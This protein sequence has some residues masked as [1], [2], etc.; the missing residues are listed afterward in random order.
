M[1]EDEMNRIFI[2]IEIIILLLG[3][4]VAPITLSLNIEGLKHTISDGNTLYV[5]GS[6]HGNYSKIQYAINNASDGDTIF[7][8][9]GIYYEDI[10][11]NKS[12]D[13][14]GE[15]REN[16]I[17]DGCREW[18]VV[19]ILADNVTVKNFYITNSTIYG[20]NSGIKIHGQRENITI[21]NNIIIDNFFGICVGD[22][23]QYER[24]F[25]VNISNNYFVNNT[26][27]LG[28][29]EGQ[30]SI[31]LNNIFVN[32]G[33]F[34]LSTAPKENIVKN[35]TING[36]SL[37]YLEE[38]SNE[39]IKPNVGQVILVNCEYIEISSQTLDIISEIGIEL[40]RCNNCNIIQ[41]QISNKYYSIYLLHSDHI[42]IQAN[43]I[44]NDTR[45]IYS[46]KS[47]SLTISFNKINGSENPV[48]IQEAHENKISYNK[49]VDGRVGLK[50]WDSNENII[51]YNN[52]E[53]FWDHGI[54][55]TRNCDKNQILNN[56]IGNCLDYGIYIY[57]PGRIWWDSASVK[58]VLSGNN[59]RKNRIGIVISH[60]LLTKV[61][62][63]NIINN[64]IGVEV[65]SARFNKIFENN[66]YENIDEDAIL[67]NSFL[68]RFI[69]NYWNDTK[70]I[71]VIKGGIYRWDFFYL[72]YYE[73]I[74]IKR[75]DWNC[76]TEPFDIGE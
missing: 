71:H 67:K 38:K 66:I 50:L 63:N 12:I 24:V 23:Y 21:Y 14:I 48:Y 25:Y 54:E 8:Y 49:F 32:N 65:R 30:E 74:P 51:S 68:S 27:G 37:V 42:N 40:V 72:F 15:D 34:I 41:N 26:Y 62:R 70:R 58:N 4:V 73:V 22:S 11:L 29:F 20:S 6:G 16:T 35:N 18:Y 5:G 75:Y 76:A 59:I 64:Y 45:S 56:T 46:Y 69:G 28:L 33:L 47:D 17:I 36:K 1:W 9:S 7:V 60:C 52:I 39:I 3:I 57:G 55:L 61:F 31:I 43:T 53:N 2:L 19:H 10:R 44:E 13:L